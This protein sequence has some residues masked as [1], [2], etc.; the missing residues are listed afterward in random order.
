MEELGTKGIGP[1]PVVAT[2]ELWSVATMLVASHGDG[3]EAHAEAQLRD[4]EERAHEGDAIVWRG[5][6][7]QLGRIRSSAG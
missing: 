3:A 2:W 7:S 6:L 5:V 4:A 1:E